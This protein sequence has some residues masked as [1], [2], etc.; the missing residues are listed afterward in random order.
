MFNNHKNIQFG[1][2]DKQL[3]MQMHTC[4]VSGGEIYEGN[5]YLL[6]PDGDVILDDQEI[7]MEKYGVV[8]RCAGE[9][10]GE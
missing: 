9:E 10:D 4:S 5:S 7:L 3:N 6:C 1:I 8:R 2:K